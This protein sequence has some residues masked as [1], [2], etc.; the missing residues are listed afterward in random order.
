MADSTEGIKRRRHSLRQL[1]ARPVTVGPV[2]VTAVREKGRLVVLIRHP[3]ETPV[4]QVGVDSQSEDIK[5][6]E[7]FVNE[8]LK[9]EHNALQEKEHNDQAN[10]QAA[11]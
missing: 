9:N 5:Q 3:E 11:G 2:T 8:L 7:A 4:A 6:C 1:L 10:Q